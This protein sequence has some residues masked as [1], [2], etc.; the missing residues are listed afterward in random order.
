MIGAF[1]VGGTQ[2]AVQQAI[3]TQTTFRRCG[4]PVIPVGGFVP[5]PLGFIAFASEWLTAGAACGALSFRRWVGAP[6][7]SLRS[8][9][10]RPGEASINRAERSE[11]IQIKKNLPDSA[12]VVYNQVVL[13]VVH[14]PVL[15]C[16]RL[17][18]FQVST[19]DRGRQ[20]VLHR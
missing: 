2:A 20:V 4:T 17:A 16:P 13:G 3:T 19:E 7:A 8:R 12:L 1:E 10:F 6:A 9:V 11:K 14:W 15:N 5:K 18:G